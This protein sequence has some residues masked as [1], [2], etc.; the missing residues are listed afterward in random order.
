MLRARRRR[1][2]HYAQKKAGE[3][4]DEPVLLHDGPPS[5]WIASWAAGKHV[6]IV[7]SGLAGCHRSDAER[8]DFLTL[9]PTRR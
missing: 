9:F 6:E 8:P 4:S 5:N 7:A 2:R 3:D 1:Q